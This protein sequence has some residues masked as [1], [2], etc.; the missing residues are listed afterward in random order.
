M[1]LFLQQVSAETMTEQVKK[2]VLDPRSYDQNVQQWYEIWHQQ[3]M[4]GSSSAS[5]KDAVETLVLS[6]SGTNGHGRHRPGDQ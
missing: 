2:H 3:L 6:K 4:L 5:E 1:N